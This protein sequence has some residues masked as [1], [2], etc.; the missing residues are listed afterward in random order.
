MRTRTF[1]QL[2]RKRREPAKLTRLLGGSRPTGRGL[3]SRFQ[4]DL[5]VTRSK[6][7]RTAGSS[8]EFKSLRVKSVGEVMSGMGYRGD[9][10][11]LR[12]PQAASMALPEPQPEPK[13]SRN[14][15]ATPSQ[16]IWVD[17]IVLECCN[18]AYDAALTHRAAEVRLEHLVFAMTRIDAA[19]EELEAHGVRVAALKREAVHV[20]MSEIPVA[21]VNGKSGP[22]RSEALEQ[23]L[24]AAEK[25]ASRRK[26]AAGV[27]DILAVLTDAGFD[28]PGL[29]RLR[30]FFMRAQALAEPAHLERRPLYAPEPMYA[31][32]YI[33]EPRPIQPDLSSLYS[34]ANYQANPSYQL[35][36]DALEQAVRSLTNDLLTER[37][38]LIAMIENLARDGT[39]HR[40]EL[41]QRL[42]SIQDRTTTLLAERVDGLEQTLEATRAAVDLLVSKPEPVTDLAPLTNRLDVIEE[43]VLSRE[44][45]DRVQALESSLAFERDRTNA[46]YDALRT[47]VQNLFGIVERQPG[48]VS[49]LVSTPL[50]NHIATLATAIEGQHSATAEALSET[51]RRLGVLDSEVQ[52]HVS[53]QN[54]RA[55]LVTQEFDALEATLTRLAATFGQE[56]STV[57]E[58]VATVS[59]DQTLLQASL[60]TKS[61]ETQSA[62]QRL[63]SAIASLEAATARP[64]AMLEE[65]SATVERMHRLMVEKYYRRNRFWYWLFG[66][67]DWVAASWPSQ[68]KRIEREINAIHTR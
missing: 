58:T 37:K 64:V 16:T 45:V 4:K 42:S 46:T 49:S 32:R 44:I 35:R 29:Q 13:R 30:T 50:Q 39:T 6:T 67:D 19:A 11:D 34:V 56:F 9:D 59:R 62:I 17:D 33:P 2:S 60:E 54:E 14:Q 40:D 1:N 28:L 57:R 66:T 3:V 25:L 36:L 21:L 68:S 53:Q 31:E 10:L 63:S 38:A 48:E 26:E 7:Q 15:R 5:P 18:Y 24:R 23:V 27:A 8:L 20:I 55:E 47:D 61:S 22:Q 52:A 43:A 41:A 12:T 51:H 65:L